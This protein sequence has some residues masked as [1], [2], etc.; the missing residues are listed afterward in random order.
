LIVMV[1][2][3]VVIVREVIGS[4]SDIEPCLNVWEATMAYPPSADSG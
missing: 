4:S 2:F 3:G 1:A